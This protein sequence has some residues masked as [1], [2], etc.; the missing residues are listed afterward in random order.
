MSDLRLGVLSVMTR[1]IRHQSGWAFGALVLVQILL[2]SPS[3]A[4]CTA[5]LSLT[6]DEK[7][8]CLTLFLTGGSEACPNSHVELFL[9]IDGGNY[10]SQLDCPSSPCTQ[11]VGGHCWPCSQG[12]H[13][14]S[15]EVA[16]SKPGSGPSGACDVGDEPGFDTKTF[17]FDHSPTI[18]GANIV[19]DDG[20]PRGSVSYHAQDAQNG[21]T[22]AAEWFGGT[23]NPNHFPPSGGDSPDYQADFSSPFRGTST[24]LLLTVEACGDK[25]AVMAV[26]ALDNECPIPDPSSS[27]CPYCFGSP[28]RASNGNM[29][30]T[31][32]DPLPGNEAISLTRTYD[33]KGLP[34]VFGNGWT[35]LFDERIRTYQS[36]A[37]GNTTF[38]EVTT[39]SNSKYVFQNVGGSWLQIYPLGIYPALL[40]P[41]TGTYTLR[42]P[43]SSIETVFDAT[44]GQV[45][46]ARSRALGRDVVIT[47]V[48][49]F[50]THVADSWGNWAWTIA[51]DS[52]NRV[53][54]IAVDGTSLVWTYA[55]NTSGNLTTVTGPS[56]APWRTYTYSGDGMTA[57][58]DAAGH[59]IESHTYGFFN[60]LTGATSSVSDHDDIT[61]VVYRLPGRDDFEKITRTTS[62]T[63]AI[64]DYYSRYI[65]GRPRTVQ[66]VGNCPTCGTNDAVYAYDLQS[67]HLLREQDARGYI[68]VREF[69]ANDRVTAVG[70]PYQPVGCNPATDTAHCRQ[71]PTTLLNVALDPTASTLTTTYAYGDANWPE[72][73]T[74][75]ATASVLSPNQV[76]STAIDLDPL[77][78]TITRQITT[79]M[80]GS[81]AQSVDLTTTTSLYDG[82]EGAAFNPGGAFDAGWLSLPQPAGLRK[83]SD[84]PR[85]DVSDTTTS[86]YYPIDNAVPASWRGHLA[87]I[88]NAAGNVIRFENYDIFG[89]AGRTI[90]A[91]GVATEF[92]FDAMG[93]VLTSTLKGVAGCDTA[94]DPLCATDLVTSRTYQPA[95]GPIAS[96]TMPGGGTTTYEYDSVGRTTA[97]TRQVTATAYERIEY[98]YD[99]ATGHK[100][101]E[102]YLGGHPGAWTVTRSDAF[103]YDLFG[104]LHIINHPDGNRVVYEYDGANNLASVKD[105]RHADANTTYAYDPRN[106]LSS[107]TQTL[108]GAPGGQ[109]ATAYGYD[110][111]GNLTS[112]TDPNGNVTS[113]VY[114]DFGRMIRQTSPV[115]GVT[116]YTYDASGN[117]LSTID[118]NSVTTTRVY[119]ALNRV[120]AATS[121][122]ESTETTSWT[123]EG[124][125]PFARGR[126]AA[127]TDPTGSTSYS[128][129]RRGALLQE[130][131]TI[132][133][134]TYTTG[135]HY[136]NDGNRSL[137]T[138]PSGRTVSYAFDLAG[139]PLT[140]TSG[141]T[142]L[143]SSATYLPF[144]PATQLVFG[145]G[146][147]KTMTYDAM[148][149]VLENRLTS[150]AGVIAYYNYAEDPVGNI[151]QIHDAIDPTFNR[152][153]GYDDLNR[154][155]TANTGSSLWGSGTYQYDAMGNMLASALGASKSTSFAYSG[156]TPKLSSVATNGNTQSVSYDPA[157][158]ELQADGHAYHYSPRNTLAD[159]D[160]VSYAYDGRGV[161]VVSSYPAYYLSTLQVTPAVLYTNQNATGTVTLASAAPA[162]GV[163]VHLSVS[164]SA[165]SVPA[166]V[167]VP[168]GGTSAVFGVTQM[169]NALPGTIT[170]TASYLYTSTATVSLVAGPPIAT[171]SVN[172]STIA[173]GG[174]ATGTV[175]LSAAAPSGGAPVHVLSD[176]TVATVPT[177]VTVA[178]GQTDASFD[179]QTSAV[180]GATTAHITADYNGTASAVLNVVNGVSSVTI[181][182]SSVIGGASVTGTVT[183]IGPAPSGGATVS[184]ISDSPSIAAVPSTVVVA[185]G[186]TTATFGISS[187]T[188]TTSAVVT[189]SASFVNS[190]VN[191]T[192]TVNPC[193]LTTAPPPTIPSGDTVWFDDTMPSG[194][195]FAD[196]RFDTSQKASGTQSLHIGY[197]AGSF[198]ED[199]AGTNATQ[200]FSV[201][202]GDRLVF[203]M[204]MNPCAKPREVEV[205]WFS[206]NS[207]PRG[208]YWGSALTGDET[209]K[210]SMGA[211]PTADGWVRMEVPASLL[212]Q[213]EGSSLYALGLS[214]YDGEVWFDRFG[215]VG[216]CTTMTEA[217]QPTIPSGDTVWFDDTMPSGMSFADI[218]FDASQKASGT[219]SLHIGYGA[220]SFGEDTAGTNATQPFPVLPGDRLVFYM[221][222]NPCA[223]P[224]EVEVT[225]FST[226]SGPRGAYWGSALTGDETGKVSMGA[227]P[228]A[229]GWV[230]MEVPA[231]L[232]YQVEGSS[233]YAL[234]LS[235]YDGEVWFD[236][237]GKVGTCTTMTEAAQPTIPSGDTVWFDDTMPSGMSFADI[238]FDASQ[239]ASGTQSLHIGYGA[240]SFG[241]DTAGT[242]ATQPFPVL[243]GDRLVFYMLMNP[244]AKPR[245]VEVTW[246][247]T[248]SG[249]RGAYWGSALTGDE[250][251][252]VSMGALPTA[253]GWVRMEVP[254]SLLYQVEG[255]SL[256]ALGLS[257]YDGE[258]WFD[259]FGKVGTCTTMTEAAQPTIPSGDT[260]WFDDTMPSGMSFA[261]I[262]FDTSQKASGTQSLHIGYGAGSFGEDTAGTNATQPFSVLPGDR[263][264]FYMLMNPCAKPREVEVTWFSTNSGPRGAYWGSALTGD[265]TGKVSM[266]A[267]PTADGWVRMEVPAS[268]L[269]QVE[270]S[271]LYALGLSRYDGEVWFD[272]FGKVGT[273]TTMTEAAQPTIPSGDTVWFDDTMPSGMSFAD[274]RFDAS[275]KASGTQSL[276]IG[277]GAGS[278][279]EDTAGTN[280]TQPFPVLPGDRLVF[281]MLM[282]PCAKPREVEV[283]WF[284]TNS[285]PR[286]AYWGSALTGD[287]T[288]KV[289]MG[290]LPTADGW[291]RM[292]VPASLLYQVE[293]SSLYALGLS[294][295]DGE[296]WFDRFGSAPGGNGSLYRPSKVERSVVAFSSQRKFDGLFVR[297]REALNR[298]FGRT[299]ADPPVSLSVHAP[300]RQS[301]PD[302]LL[303]YSLYTPELNLMAETEQTTAPTPAIAYEYVWFGGQPVAQ[304]D[305]ATNT[306]H[307]TFT[308][309]LGTTIL[310]TNAAGAVDWRVEYEPYGTFDALRAGATRHQPLRFP[311]QEY[312]GASADRSYNVFRWYR[313]GWGKYTQ[314]D[315]LEFKG[316]INLFAYALENTLRYKDPLGLKVYRCCAPA[317][318]A[319]GLVDHCW[320]KTD[321]QQTQIGFADQGQPAGTDPGGACAAPFFSQT[322]V[323]IYR[324]NKKGTNCTEITDADEKCV[325]DATRTNSKGWGSTNG[326]WT[327]WNQCQSWTDDVLNKC[328]KKCKPPV[329]PQPADDGKRYF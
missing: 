206:T 273:C 9:A 194:M 312:D 122:G 108:P 154:L 195:S 160:L 16:C 88:R 175:S 86:V 49:G 101:A 37:L 142:T 240:G 6:K 257:R 2:C 139:R 188:V 254:A 252:K 145:N 32:R 112:V 299:H 152:D 22:L 186:A 309:H 96:T 111:H 255:S 178:A 265:E 238:R 311:G 329:G 163:V 107:V 120:T 320:I 131:K 292:E 151:T 297:F 271:S 5:S 277:Y 59:L 310:Q 193:T 41:G 304:F 324:G 242:N 150:A 285:G 278:F 322:Q 214:R 104:R 54:S 209:G 94:A 235:R 26:N 20:S 134:A 226:N 132:G 146:T 4:T 281:Y 17:S 223:K 239:K 307:W 12:T 71:T 52:A 10:V 276:H 65:A 288:G 221:L 87:A 28:I 149:R 250:T 61:S 72:I 63:G 158:N 157:G 179:I 328:K 114:D 110:I 269:Y 325:D 229:D 259:R 58:N 23:T 317:D 40:I 303:R 241:E 263:L 117:L 31:E 15:L 128:Y 75:T 18:T 173:G 295:Y 279:G 267:L 236:R 199:T 148:Y 234:G 44:T 207:G 35:S 187:Y 123:Y 143:V 77:T 327:P 270:G 70:G 127:M 95:L 290:A 301:S 19:S 228:T 174:T 1:G 177:Q 251:G 219:Q 266:G 34:G 210:V 155:V 98:D 126:L 204:L 51:P 202:P 64:T 46:R 225:W 39:A 124:T 212:Y 287:E 33:S 203:Y 306:T 171:V 181:N 246:F 184:L 25:K 280:A 218:R 294:R 256:Y 198:G 11:T 125:G 79:G 140:A 305:I 105:E 205:T 76:R 233:L 136:D 319:G 68:T 129:E 135:Y 116:T 84:G 133:S 43:R 296:V 81:P 73:A 217:A 91:N 248:N 315:P 321:K 180:T 191:A 164:S 213:V 243:P 89:N 253:D 53:N 323:Q 318:V 82:A 80:T 8:S 137:M 261:D 47:W 100:S 308:D 245:E 27:S 196:I 166:T 29:R 141:A 172:P 316:G 121:S 302:P 74:L 298:T 56:N 36:Q 215:K 244:C 258:V 260:V 66:I 62:G 67:G 224:R 57:A 176:S 162:G 90:D 230:R 92:T 227:L 167:T 38:L 109:I 216:T 48:G 3:E 13:S 170:I 159:A 291:V 85:T 262:R 313:V 190:S 156:T 168:A 55:Y 286:G 14:W 300:I 274:I 222:M 169:A 97:T 30:M 165:F 182:P 264:V 118:A 208:A 147:T 183:L 284:S 231:S 283:T 106:R 99:P 211:L 189:I 69:D 24:T 201:L 282:N 268:L 153:F 293:G 45:L 237:F 103:Q 161:L 326:A 113:Y 102:R 83:I 197:G 192:L 60:G 220:G 21:T 200:P 50:P 232:L 185:A 115:T 78:G 144:G 130:L 247:S 138:Y 7:T 275:Q 249:P 119:D 289:S 42:E 272:R 314:A 93:R